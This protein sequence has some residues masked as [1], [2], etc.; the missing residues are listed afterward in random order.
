MPSGR[1]HRQPEPNSP[2]FF[3]DRSLGRV[4]IAA[5]LVNRGFVVVPM[6]EL[7][8]NGRDQQ[9]VDDTWI[10][11]VSRL[12]HVALTKD[13]NILKHH[14]EALE[15]STLRVFAI[16]SA[17]VSGPEMAERIDF[18]LRRILQRAQRPGPYFY[19][20]HALNIE[21]RWRPDS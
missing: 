21:L 12:G 16:D 9:V 8:P 5:L 18:H 2:T 15:T 6:H 7:Y 20:I 14:R 1:R 10:S 11:D 17:Q 4:H 13:K 3:L 19:V